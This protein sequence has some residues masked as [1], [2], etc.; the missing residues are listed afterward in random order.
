MK[1]SEPVIVL[2][3]QR[4]ENKYLIWVLEGNVRIFQ[5]R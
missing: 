5:P 3:G 4:R 2:I 1:S